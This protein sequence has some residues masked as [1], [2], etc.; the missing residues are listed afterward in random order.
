ML[1]QRCHQR[2]FKKPDNLYKLAVLPCHLV[3]AKLNWRKWLCHNSSTVMIC[4]YTNSQ[5]LPWKRLSIVDGTTS[6]CL[7]LPEDTIW[8]TCL[9]MSTIL[10][11]PSSIHN[12]STVAFCDLSFLPEKRDVKEPH[13]IQ[14]GTQ[15][16]RL[17]KLI[18]SK[19]STVTELDI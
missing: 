13:E 16:A 17:Q 14:S 8:L 11:C 19:V 12:K 18:C 7:N 5:H 4:T 6:S 1:T 15:Y 2:I 3:P 9:A 10:W